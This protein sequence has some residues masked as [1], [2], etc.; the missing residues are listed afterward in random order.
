MKQPRDKRDGEC[1][2][3][4]TQTLGLI[5]LLSLLLGLTAV[6]SPPGWWSTRGTVRAPQVVTNAG[7]VTTN[8]VANDYA[9][10][11]Q[12]QIKQFTARAVDE[13]NANLPGGAGTNLNGMVTNWVTDYA[14]N[15][16]GATNLKPSDFNVLNVGQVKYIGNKVWSRLVAAG[17]TNAVPSWLA[18]NTN[19][20]GVIAILG[21]L[22]TIFNFDLSA[23]A[24]ATPTFSP[25]SGTYSTSQTVTISSVTSGAIIYYT[26]D[27]STPTTSSTS[28]ASGSSLTVSASKTLRAFA[29][30]SGHASSA[31]ASA[32]YVINLPR[33]LRQHFKSSAATAR[34]DLP[35]QC[36]H[37]H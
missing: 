25:G 21:Q 13:M 17:Y 10:V 20:D 22:K 15:G 36:W 30:V 37:H 8:Y 34:S 19:T 18:V 29:A 28:F 26:T 31:V 35:E 14:T 33:R 7:V 5:A 27:G 3:T 16:Y 32:A 12:G 11:T 6:G 4:I 24:T 9:A 23:M 1:S 2:A